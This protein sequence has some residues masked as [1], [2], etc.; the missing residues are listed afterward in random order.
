[1]VPKEIP[2][3]S[4]PSKYCCSVQDFVDSGVKSSEIELDGTKLETAYQGFHKAI[5]AQ[6]SEIVKLSR[7]NGTLFIERI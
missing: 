2:V 7:V 6:F 5:K 4:R 3:K 1:M